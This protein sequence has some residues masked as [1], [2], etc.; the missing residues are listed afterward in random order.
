MFAVKAEDEG[1]D[2]GEGGLSF[3]YFTFVDPHLG[4]LY[5]S[6]IFFSLVFFYFSSF[7]TSFSFFSNSCLSQIIF[8]LATLSYFL[9]E[10]SSALRLSIFF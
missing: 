10:A 8:V 4:H 2:E 3:E 6:S 5:S 1:D 9:T 7:L